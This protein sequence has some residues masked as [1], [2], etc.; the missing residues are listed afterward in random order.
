MSLNGHTGLPRRIAARTLNLSAGWNVTRQVRFELVRWAD[1]GP[2]LHLSLIAADLNGTS[3]M[4]LKKLSD[5]FQRGVGTPL[6]AAVD[7]LLGSLGLGRCPTEDGAA[8]RI[9]FTIAVVALSA[10]MA[11]ADGVVTE[12]EQEMFRQVFEAEAG[13]VENVQRIF[14]LAKEDVAGFDSYARQI[15]TMLAGEPELKRD[16]LEGLFNIAAADGILHEQEERYLQAVAEILEISSETFRA[17]RAQFVADPDGAY[18]VL[19]LDPGASNDVVRTRYRRLVRENHPDAMMARGVPAE[20]LDMATR[21]LAAINSAY[22]TIAR[23]R[24][25]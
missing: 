2:E 5:A 23:E 3:E 15:A 17:I 11:K 22:E 7:H 20:F 4:A 6:R 25:L 18:S 16:V 24:G 9:A 19:G 14:D 12:I 21:K 1:Y 13:E 10:K 8:N